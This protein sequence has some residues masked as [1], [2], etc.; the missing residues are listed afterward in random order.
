MEATFATETKFISIAEYLELEE[1]SLS[2]HEFN[3]GKLMEMAGSSFTH[4]RLSAALIVLFTNF[5]NQQ[6]SVFI[7][8]GSDQKVHL[9]LTNKIVYTDVAVICEKPI[10]FE[11]KKLILTNPTLIVEVLSESTENYDRG[12]KFERYCS[13]PSFSEYLLLS[14]DAMHAEVFTLVDA[15]NDLWRIQR[16]NGAEG[17]VFLKSI[18]FELNL[19]ELYLNIL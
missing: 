7:A 10:F 12:E 9:P 1:K 6:K 14:Q 4:N 18:G 2:K 17:K 19:G 13:I 16:A 11:E 5:F 3:D 15:E 8:V